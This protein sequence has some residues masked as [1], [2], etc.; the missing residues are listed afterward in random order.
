MRTSK[1]HTLSQCGDVGEPEGAQDH[2]RPAPP[3]DLAAH[4]SADAHSGPKARGITRHKHGNWVGRE[5]WERG[6]K[7]LRR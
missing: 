3:Q 4:I 5:R 1:P 6:D 7:S 2:D